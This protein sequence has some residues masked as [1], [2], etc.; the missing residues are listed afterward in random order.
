MHSLWKFYFFNVDLVV[1]TFVI[2]FCL[3]RLILRV[4]GLGTGGEILMVVKCRSSPN[5]KNTAI[6]LRQP[7]THFTFSFRIEL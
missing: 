1:I 4:F 2:V 5:S 3:N 7:I 6:K